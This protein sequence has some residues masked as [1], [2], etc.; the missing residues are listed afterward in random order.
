LI[1]SS[2]PQIAENG[3]ALHSRKVWENKKALMT[4]KFVR[5]VWEL[6]DRKEWKIQL[7]KISSLARDVHHV[8]GNHGKNGM[9][10]WKPRS[11]G[12]KGTLSRFSATLSRQE[13]FILLTRTLKYTSLCKH[14]RSFTHQFSLKHEIRSSIVVIHTLI[15]NSTQLKPLQPPS[16]PRPYRPLYR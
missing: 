13:H 7:A 12:R 10:L 6:R 4:D 14:P 1:P 15:P 5:R 8:I 11:I 9:K 16:P 2:G 3:R